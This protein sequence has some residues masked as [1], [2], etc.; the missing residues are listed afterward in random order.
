MLCKL[1]ILLSTTDL[2]AVESPR[3]LNQEE[4][5]RRLE[6]EAAKARHAQLERQ[7]TRRSVNAATEAERQRRLHEHKERTARLASAHDE[8]GWLAV[9]AQLVPVVKRSKQLA[10]VN[11]AIRRRRL[12]TFRTLLMGA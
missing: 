3:S 1:A 6:E 5:V 8:R 7:A 9:E 12:S 2:R 4:R 10:L 11:D